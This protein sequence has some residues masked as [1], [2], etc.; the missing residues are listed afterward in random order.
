MKPLTY[1]DYIASI[2]VGADDDILFGKIIGINDLIVFE[3]NTIP[4]LKKAF[5]EAVDD[6][7]ET[8]KELNKT[9]EKSYKGS[10]NVRVPGEL[11]RIAA[12]YASANKKSL[13]EVIV[14][15]LEKYLHQ[16]RYISA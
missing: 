14:A 6:Y 11:H 16:Q 1:K 13:N 8:C 10:F 9:P 12:Y 3:G 15:A 7:L 5:K 2:N 4:E